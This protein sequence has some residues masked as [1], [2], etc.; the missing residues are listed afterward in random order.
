MNI[1][2]SQKSAASDR[3]RGGFALA[4]AAGA[5]GLA[6]QVVWARRFSQFF[7]VST[8]TFAVVLAMVLAGL[9]LG[10]VLVGRRAD[11]AR[12]PARL[13]ALLL[14]ACGAAV[15]IGIWLPAVVFQAVGYLFPEAAIGGGT[16][17]TVR[18][19]LGLLVILP[20]YVML[21]G[22]IPSL[23][24][25]DVSAAGQL[26]GRISIVYA[27]ETLGGAIGGL[28]T[29]FWLLHL[30]GL[31][32]TL[33]L[34]AACCLLVGGGFYAVTGRRE[35]TQPDAEK[36]DRI[37]TP[38][39]TTWADAALLA[40]VVAAS[41]SALGL[42]VVW[43]RLLL[44]ILGS[45]VYSYT[46]V[47]TSFL[48]GISIGALLGRVLCPRLPNP[49]GAFCWLQLAV[50][51][52]SVCLLLFF[53]WLAAGPGQAWLESSSSLIANRFLLCFGL[54]LIPTTLLGLSLPFAA[55]FLLRRVN[56][57]ATRAGWLLAAS[58]VGNILG[59]LAT[60]FWFV[61]QMGI[62]FSV[63]TLA[64]ASLLAA[65]LAAFTQAIMAVKSRAKEQNS[66]IAWPQIAT[67]FAAIAAC[68]AC[69]WYWPNAPL[70][71]SENWRDYEVTYYREGP[72]STVMVLQHRQQPE[73]RM[74]TVDGI[75]IGESE[76][77][78]DEKQRM[79]AHLPFVLR[80]QSEAQHVLTIGLGTG[81]L[82]GELI[83]NPAVEDVTCV[84]L[85]P[86]VIEAAQEFRSYSGNIF[87]DQ[88][89]A[90][91]AADGIH[92]VQQ[93]REKF[94]AIISDGKSQP[95]HAGNA[96]FFSAEYYQS[97]QQCLS[98]EGIMT[99]W[100][101][102]EM[103]P[104]TVRLILRTFADAFP[105]I[106]AG[107]AGTDSLYLVGA[108]QQLHLDVPQ[109]Q[110]Y[111][112]SDEAAALRAYQ[113]RDAWDILSLMAI[114]RAGVDRWLGVAAPVNSLALPRL[115][116]HATES[117]RTSREE[118]KRANLMAL[119][120]PVAFG[121]EDLVIQGMDVEPSSLRKA[122]SLLLD[123]AILSLDDSANNEQSI[124]EKNA[125]ALKLAPRI[126][127]VRIQAADAAKH[128]ARTA[129][130]E[131]DI[132]TAFQSYQ[133]AT[134]LAP[135]DARLR[136]EFARLLAESG[137]LIAAAQQYHESLKIDPDDVVTRMN[138]AFTLKTMGKLRQAARQFQR[139]VEQQPTEAVAH[140]ELGVLLLKLNNAAQSDYHLRRAVELDPK[141]ENE[142]AASQ[143]NL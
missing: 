73:L 127:T 77:G 15:C 75:I 93:S 46:L 63:I 104:A 130:S 105:H 64:G 86:A 56:D 60:G 83:K 119:A 120:E 36:D 25:A 143:H 100:V 66:R 10:A 5:V 9:A 31:Q 58:S 128:Q 45:D 122:R 76:G 88:R 97:C 23:T 112:Q 18:L 51:F 98:P 34:T 57:A 1:N 47:V 74:M 17:S 33:W 99:Q 8:Q 109:M 70:G 16:L 62:Q 72:V 90:V 114:D 135:N 24:R 19:V 68:I 38:A 21:G 54:L 55:S 69:G 91:V 59:A 110:E 96:A 124:A 115:E 111:L 136:H 106:Y 85:S 126:S 4:F 53:R 113:W 142:I 26:P 121:V 41:F 6:I 20:P 39:G 52:A 123:M 40:A 2:M 107:I 131:G 116:A 102:L 101:S 81:I 13:A 140:L 50:G 125:E 61:P 129:Q 138:F 108:N 65:T 71:M 82:A 7:G 89:V 133:Q 84:E 137:D 67:V 30:C 35:G 29:G 3:L 48:L 132:V 141:L 12:Q 103:P 49:L 14:A 139:V 11:H 43:T 27:L 22:V 37:E 87:D 32:G 78:V 92:Y 95:G 80:P 94:D 117:F 79:L 44:L 42:E 118:R 134:Q 28:I